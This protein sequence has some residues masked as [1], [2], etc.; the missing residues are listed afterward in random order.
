MSVPSNGHF[1]VQVFNHFC[2]IYSEAPHQF[3]KQK[4]VQ[5]QM[6]VWLNAECAVSRVRP[7]ETLSEFHFRENIAL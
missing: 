1:L 6:S 7:P 5:S 4:W 2:G 3:Q